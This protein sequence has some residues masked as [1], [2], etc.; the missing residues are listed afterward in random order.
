MNYFRFVLRPAEGDGSGALFSRIFSDLISVFASMVLTAAI[1][2]A[3]VLFAQSENALVGSVNGKAITAKE[4]DESVFSQLLPLKQQ[5]Y[6]LRKTALENLITRRVLEETAGQ[7]GLS[8]DQLKQQLK[9]GRVEIPS[10]QV[11]QLFA[12]NAAAFAAMGVDEAKERL[13]LDLE[14]Q[15]RMKLYRDGV[16]ELKKKAKIELFLE[17]PR[18]PAL[19]DLATAPALGPP[20]APV[21][22]IEFSDF[23]CP[24]CRASQL[25]LKQIL[26]DYK[27]EV[28]LVFKHLPLDIHAE[29]F[30]SAQAAFCAGE[31]KA[32]WK[33]HDAVF[34]AEDLSVEALTRMA[35]D[36][37]LNVPGFKECLRSEGS[38]NQVLQDTR[39]ARQ[40]GIT[41]TPTFL[42]N[43]KLIS[44][45]IGI[46]EFKK[47]IEGELRLFR[48]A[49]A[50]NNFQ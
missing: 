12:E 7:R 44:G 29:A 23:Q 28:R 46:E 18:F 27:D 41:G 11:D 24:F 31:Q 3:N 48:A 16:A 49:P 37:G 40:F 25:T 1:G 17:E 19:A 33:Y 20:N 15:A 6:A 30:V 47:I 14:T 36:L 5:I 4:V 50:P 21:T 45:A 22:V 42:V 32:F 10:T 34:S 13:R 26:R 39:D 9:S 8:V 35:A 2:S 38:R 43:G